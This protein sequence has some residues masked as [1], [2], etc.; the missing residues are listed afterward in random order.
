MYVATRQ[1]GPFHDVGLSQTVYMTML[2]S[3]L[4]LSASS[5]PPSVLS[6]SIEIAKRPHQTASGCAPSHVIIAIK[7]IIAIIYIAIIYV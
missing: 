6:E 2:V 3:E 4:R 5:I 1:P 7:T